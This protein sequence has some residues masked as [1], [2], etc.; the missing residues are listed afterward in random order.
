MKNIK[1]KRL[2][3]TIAHIVCTQYRRIQERKYWNPQRVLQD[4]VN[5]PDCTINIVY[6]AWIR[7]I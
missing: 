7:Q 6:A 5:I 4:M 1:C 3:S 2:T